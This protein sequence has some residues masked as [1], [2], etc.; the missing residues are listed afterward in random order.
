MK[1]TLE[2]GTTLE[3]TAEEIKT[4]IREMTIQGVVDRT[5][6]H[7]ETIESSDDAGHVERHKRGRPKG[8]RGRSKNADVYLAKICDKYCVNVSKYKKALMNSELGFEDIAKKFKIPKNAVHNCRFLLRKNGTIIFRY[9]K[10]TARMKTYED[11]RKRM[12][13]CRKLVRSGKAKDMSQ[14][15]KMLSKRGWK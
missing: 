1:A 7:K 13:K 3:G 9:A 12:K 4:V 14:A 2:N 6:Y 5:S 15:M 10:T 11:A 8:S